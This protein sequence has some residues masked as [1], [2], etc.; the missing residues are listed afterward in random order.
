M[1]RSQRQSEFAVLSGLHAVAL[2]QV[3]EAGMFAEEGQVYR[4]DGSVTLFADDELGIAVVILGAAVVPLAAMFAV[5]RF[6]VDEHD[7]VGILLD[8]A[9]FSQVAH[10]GALVGPFFQFAVELGER[11]YR[12]A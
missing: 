1:C 6:A 7:Y 8:G 12:Y 3:F 4:A 11:N 5:D 2:A 9:R 10:H